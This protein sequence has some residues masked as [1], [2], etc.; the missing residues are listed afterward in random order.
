MRQWRNFKTRR[1]ADYSQQSPPPQMQIDKP[2]ATFL[3]Q[4]LRPRDNFDRWL[5]AE[6]DRERVCLVSVPA[7]WGAVLASQAPPA[8]L[9][10]DAQQ[11]K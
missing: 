4:A 6:I 1:Q 3:T 7:S 5:D 11:E 9:E 2:T 10:T 8:S